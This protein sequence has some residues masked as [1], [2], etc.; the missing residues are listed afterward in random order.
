MELG[1]PWSLSMELGYSQVWVWS[2][3]CPEVSVMNC[4]SMELGHSQ[5]WVCSW[6]RPEVWIWSWDILRFEYD[7]RITLKFEYEVGISSGLTE[8]GA[9]HPVEVFSV[10]AKC[11]RLSGEGE[12]KPRCNT[13][14]MCDVEPHRSLSDISLFARHPQEK[15][16]GVR[17]EQRWV[18]V[19]GNGHAH[20]VLMALCLSIIWSGGGGRQTGRHLEHSSC[21]PTQIDQM[22]SAWS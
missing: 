4:L 11:A 3:D 17:G 20:R 9:A 7:V 21:L 2:W 5:V 6:D 22:R 16:G 10:W 8:Y 13:F 14:H 18:E 19:S 12:T 1:S 15:G